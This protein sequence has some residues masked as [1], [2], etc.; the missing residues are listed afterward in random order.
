MKDVDNF[1][2]DLSQA[3]MREALVKTVWN[4]GFGC[5]NRQGFEHLVW[6][7]IREEARWIIYFDVDGMHELNEQYGYDQVNEM[8]KQVLSIVR[9]SDYIAGQRFSGDEFVVV[10]TENPDHAPL[11]PEGMVERL[12]QELARH[13]MSATFAYDAVVWPDLTRNVKRAAE[14]VARV[15]KMRGKSP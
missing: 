2:Q 1:I 3:E 4:E 8:I 6:P 11:D 7:Q 5:F 13:G 10:L 12:V 14:S 15:K 9:S